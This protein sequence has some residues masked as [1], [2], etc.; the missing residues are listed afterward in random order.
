MTNPK[1][2]FGAAHS[3]RVGSLDPFVYLSEARSDATSRD[4]AQAAVIFSQGEPADAV[5]YIR[6]GRVK[7]SLLSARGKEAIIAILQTG[8]FLGEGCLA[9]QAVRWS[10]ATALSK[11]T[12]VRIPVAAMLKALLEA[13]FSERFMAHLLARNIRFEE[14]LTDQ[15]FNSSERRLARALLLL[16]NFGKEGRSEPVVAKISQKNLAELVGTTRSRVSFFMNKFRRLGLIEYGGDDELRV[17]SSLL[18]VVL[19]D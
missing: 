14:D 1:T 10:S 18:N 15:L 3:Q 4:Y 13:D 6:S 16:A 17:H 12:L 11:A 7:L 2:T 9:G 8:D 5:Y 19:H